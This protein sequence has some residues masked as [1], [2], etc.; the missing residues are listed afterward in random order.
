[1]Y[2]SP[3]GMQNDRR[4]AKI[5]LWAK[6]IMKIKARTRIATKNVLIKT[7]SRTMTELT[8]TI[9]HI[10]FLRLIYLREK[11]IVKSTN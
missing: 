1:M 3:F 11:R 4:T 5:M 7:E 10:L 8:T 9:A 2:I 6:T